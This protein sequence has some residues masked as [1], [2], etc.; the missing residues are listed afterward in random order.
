[1]TIY[2]AWKAQIALLL[3]KKVIV[4]AK[5][6][7][8]SEIFLKKLAKVL[9]KCIRIYKH[10]IKLENGKQSP[11]RSIY[12]LNLLEFKTLKTYIKTNLANGFIQSSKSLTSATILFVCKSNGSF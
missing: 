5:Y 6:I 2:L 7:D 3:F 8:F 12:S 10:A 11:Y 1:M 4:L 9:S